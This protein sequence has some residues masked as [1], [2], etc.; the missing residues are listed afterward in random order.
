VSQFRIAAAQYGFEPLRSLA[1]WRAKMTRWLEEAALGG[2]ALAIFPEYGAMELA[3]VA[4]P[5]VAGDLLRSIRNERLVQLGSEADAHLSGEARRLGLHVLG[6][7][8]AVLRDGL[9]RNTARLFAP[10]GASAAQEKRVMT[11][12]ERELWGVSSGGA[13]RVFETALGR[14]GIAICYD[15]EF[16]LIARAL[17][18]SGADIILAPSCTDS[19]AGYWRVRVGAQARALENQCYTVQAPTVGEAAWCPAVDTNH[20]AAGVFGPPDLGFPPDGVVALG[21]MDRPGWLFGDIDLSKVAEVREQGRVFNHRHWH[22][23]GADVVLAP[24]ELVS[25]TQTCPD[26]CP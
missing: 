1:A 13:L 10:S 9:W 16:P 14:I 2:A 17:A 11:R 15:A 23:Q 25:L 6:P 5:E 4:G 12:F 7:S 26:I 19:M 24:V 3:H 20:G 8:R 18:V 22:E 21:E